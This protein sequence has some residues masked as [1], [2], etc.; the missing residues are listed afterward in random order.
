MGNEAKVS[1]AKKL[2]E[3]KNDPS[4]FIKKDELVIAV[5]Q[6]PEGFLVFI[7]SKSSVDEL[8]LSQARLSRHINRAVD[9]TE[10]QALQDARNNKRIIT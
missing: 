7:N 6:T 5:K 1:A 4:A 8:L 10:M 9:M 3:Y 2:E